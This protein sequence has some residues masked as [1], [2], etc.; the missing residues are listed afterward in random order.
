M[1]KNKKQPIVLPDSSRLRP[2]LQH[3][4]VPLQIQ[5]CAFGLILKLLCD[6]VNMFEDYR[7]ICPDD[8]IITFEDAVN[9]LTD[10]VTSVI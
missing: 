4:V 10:T 5:R 8:T 9:I 2:E 3:D 1:D 7:M 6:N